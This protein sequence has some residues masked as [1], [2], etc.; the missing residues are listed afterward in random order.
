[1]QC[2]CATMTLTL[3]RNDGSVKFLSVFNAKIPVNASNKRPKHSHLMNTLIIITNADFQLR[4]SHILEHF[5][6]LQ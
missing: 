5:L 3:T 1:M 2:L 4:V 6:L